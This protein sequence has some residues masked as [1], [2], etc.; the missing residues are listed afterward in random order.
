METVITGVRVK[1]I[2]EEERVR[3]AFTVIFLSILSLVL[4][5]LRA[6]SR[7]VQKHWGNSNGNSIIIGCSSEPKP[8]SVQIGSESLTLLWK[9]ESRGLDKRKNEFV[10]EKECCHRCYE[11]ISCRVL[12][13][14]KL[15]RTKC[16]AGLFSNVISTCLEEE[17][18][19]DNYR[20]IF[21]EIVLV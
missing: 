9:L 2:S 10:S 7:C 4:S 13:T 18:G 19:E 12:R 15:S 11:F 16:I 8:G 3:A 17:G 21:I 5:I 6:I 14:I 1:A 20:H